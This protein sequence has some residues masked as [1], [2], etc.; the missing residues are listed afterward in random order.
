MKHLTPY[1]TLSHDVAGKLTS[2]IKNHKGLLTSLRE[3]CI[4]SNSYM[5]V[6]EELSSALLHIVKE[7]GNLDIEKKI[8]RVCYYLLTDMVFAT[9]SDKILSE[10]MRH[11]QY[12]IS[13]ADGA[14]LCLAWRLLARIV[15]HAHCAALIEQT[16]LNDIKSLK[17]PAKEKKGLLGTRKTDFEQQVLLWS[18]HFSAMRRAHI[19]PPQEFLETFFAACEYGNVA[20]AR[21]AYQ[22]L[23]ELLRSHAATVAPSFVLKINTGGF[24]SR[25]SSDIMTCMH[26]LE[27]CQ[28][29]LKDPNST[30]KMVQ[31]LLV[32]VFQL[33]GNSKY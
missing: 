25:A 21:H 26:L 24:L 3:L 4:H 22:L 11:L 29:V 17:K 27:A 33:L 30:V 7:T 12:E 23:A 20:L 6:N 14:R 5:P 10:V 13:H 31:D 32:V 18:S 1:A 8:I 15:H 19:T 28:I 16:L 2:K 9:N